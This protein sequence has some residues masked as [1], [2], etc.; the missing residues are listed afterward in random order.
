MNEICHNIESYEDFENTME[1][2]LITDI[3]IDLYNSYLERHY[4][5]KRV[6]ILKEIIK[7]NNIR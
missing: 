2:Y 5:S 7:R 3:D 1:K 6:E 4:T